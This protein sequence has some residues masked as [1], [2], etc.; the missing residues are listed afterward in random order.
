[1]VNWYFF[2]N[3]YYIRRI[4]PC[5]I[6]LWFSIY[7]R[8]NVTTMSICIRYEM[9]MYTENER[10][11]MWISW[12][13]HSSWIAKSLWSSPKPFS[14]SEK[15]FRWYFIILTCYCIVVYMVLFFFL[16]HPLEFYF[17]T[18]SL[19]RCI[20]RYMVTI[21]DATVISYVCEL[22]RGVKFECIIYV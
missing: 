2:Y 16:T 11:L 9:Q 12:S 1:M 20:L 19:Y 13:I 8:A 22:P 6:C 21:M 3:I 17:R 14:V 18:F 5:Y 15:S 10:I 7:T 4:F